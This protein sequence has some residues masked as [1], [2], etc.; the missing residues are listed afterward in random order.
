MVVN[1]V[2]NQQ[3]VTTHFPVRINLILA[4]KL[5]QIMF[6]FA[7]ARSQLLSPEEAYANKTILT[8]TWHLKWELSYLFTK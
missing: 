1:K 6:L 2:V 5:Y 3:M 4:I 8:L 7:I